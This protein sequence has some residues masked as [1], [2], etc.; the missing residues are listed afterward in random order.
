M[1][2]LANTSRMPLE[3]AAAV[4]EAN[5][6]DNDFM[7][8]FI[9][10]SQSLQQ[11]SWLRDYRAAAETVMLSGF[12]VLR[13]ADALE[14]ML[15]IT[16]SRVRRTAIPVAL[17]DAMDSLTSIHRELTDPERSALDPAPLALIHALE[18]TC[19][20]YAV[21]AGPDRATCRHAR[22]AVDCCA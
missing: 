15:T 4:Y 6:A 13:T 12:A 9:G 11:S 10:K 18:E 14:A 5:A 3:I 8:H 21:I 19:Q 17:R 7:A 16:D 20:D 2:A 1:R 22:L